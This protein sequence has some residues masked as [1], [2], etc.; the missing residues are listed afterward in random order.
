MEHLTGKRKDS[1]KAKITAR[2]D[3][4]I[5]HLGKIRK[6]KFS[7]SRPWNCKSSVSQKRVGSKEPEQSLR[8]RS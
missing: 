1:K 2:T 3:I 6:L 7:K 4:F 8:L 5:M